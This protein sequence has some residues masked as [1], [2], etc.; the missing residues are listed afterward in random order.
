MK[1]GATNLG[2]DKNR[3]NANEGIILKYSSF[4]YS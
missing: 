4:C 1:K 2:G 3:K